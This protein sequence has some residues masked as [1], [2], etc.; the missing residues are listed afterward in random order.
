MLANNLHLIFHGVGD[1]ITQ[2][3]DGEERYFISTELFHDVI[4]SLEALEQEAKVKV[5]ISFDDG[6]LSDIIHGLPALK[7]TGRTAIF[8][9]LAGRIGQKGYLSG[10]QFRELQSEGMIIGSQGWDHVNWSKLDK[11][12]RRREF[13]DARKRIED[14]IGAPVDFAGIPYG[15]FDKT[16]LQALK[17]EE[18]KRVFSSSPGLANATSWLCP[19]TSIT[20]DFAPQT[21]LKGFASC[22]Q[23]IR[24]TFYAPL[25]RLKYRY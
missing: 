7:A 2:L 23:K 17:R 6:N 14:E 24:G 5:H 19:R 25:R 12:G 11:A 3:S 18:Y 13:V 9:V 4:D 1:P 21:S 10:A 20:S 16:V 15:A 22:K 8:F